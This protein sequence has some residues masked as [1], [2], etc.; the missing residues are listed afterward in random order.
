MGL[1]SIITGVGKAG[2]VIDTGMDVVKMGASGLDKLV[3]T[4]EEKA[5]DGAKNIA[6]NM[7]HAI[8]MARIAQNESGASAVTRRLVFLIVLGNFTIYA[9]AALVAACFSRIDI[10]TNIIKTA[11]AIMLGEMAI[12]VVV[13]MAGYYAATKG[14]K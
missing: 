4:K 2:D 3:Y 12:A 1:W 14:R 13:S 7:D 9:Q 10:I 5:I 6:V 8:T 11:T